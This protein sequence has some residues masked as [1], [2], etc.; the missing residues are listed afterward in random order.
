[1]DYGQAPL[2]DRLIDEDPANSRESAQQRLMDAREIKALVVRDL[3]NLLNCR[4]SIASI[5]DEL[6]ELQNSVAVYGLKDFTA[7]GADSHQVRQTILKDVEK[8]IARF[9]PRLKNVNVVIETGDHK[10]RSLSFQISAMLV[11]DP[12]REPVAFDTYFD[13][14]RKAFVISG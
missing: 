6:R 13:T 2:L 9:E 3:E 5:P 14:T 4:R 12:I 1:M 7:L 8:A 10:E 11:V